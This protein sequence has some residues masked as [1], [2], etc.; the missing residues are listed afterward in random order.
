[1]FNGHVGHDSRNPIARA[2][3]R[4]YGKIP[5]SGSDFHDPT[6]VI[7]AGIQTDVPITDMKQLYAV[8]RSGK[9]TIH[10]GGARALREHLTD[11]PAA[12]L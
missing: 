10:C 8:L 11:F 2:W 7:D 3:C 1:M 5:T 12:D 6:S 4:T 9:Y